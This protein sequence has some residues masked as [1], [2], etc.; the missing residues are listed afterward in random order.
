MRFVSSSSYILAD[1]N[2]FILQFFSVCAATKGSPQTRLDAFSLVLNALIEL[3]GDKHLNPDVYTW[4]AVWKTC[5]NQLDLKKDLV[6]INRVFDLTIK[7]GKVDELL[8]NNMRNFLPPQ[9]LQ[10]KL[11]TTVDVQ[12]LTVHDLPPAWTCNVKLGRERG[13]GSKKNAIKKG[14]AA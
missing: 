6:W 13:R 14:A 12:S 10:K 9:Y 4:P 5:E 1:I 2:I 11:K 8:F 3:Q 7:S